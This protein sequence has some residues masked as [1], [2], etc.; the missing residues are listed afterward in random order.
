MLVSNICKLID[1]ELNDWTKDGVIK[2]VSRIQAMNTPLFDSL[3]NKLE[4][5]PEM[6]KSLY[7]VLTQGEKFSYNPDHEPTRLL[8]MFGFIRIEDNSIVIAN[9]IFETRLYND[10]L[11]SEEIKSTPIAKAGVFDKPEFIKDGI[12]DVELIFNRFICHFTEIYGNRPSKSLKIQ[13]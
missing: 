2:A 4:S 1:E 12:L 11:T 7:Q 13:S 6:K 5:Y 10:M 8:L 3:I 9:R